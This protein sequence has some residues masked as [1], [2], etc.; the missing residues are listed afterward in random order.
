MYGAGSVFG[1]AITPKGVFGPVTSRG[2]L[3]R[4]SYRCVYFNFSFF[5]E[6]AQGGLFVFDFLI[7]FLL[8]TDTYSLLL[9]TFRKNSKRA[10]RGKYAPPPRA[11][12]VD[13]IVLM[14]FVN[15][16]A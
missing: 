6:W 15:L 4:G 8:L 9:R 11:N 2:R 14:F 3:T 5:S 13:Y 1:A 10:K 16:F 7:L 12:S